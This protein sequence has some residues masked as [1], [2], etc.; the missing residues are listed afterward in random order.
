[1]TRK[2]TPLK[3]GDVNRDVLKP[4]CKQVGFPVGMMHAFR[5][6]RVS[7]MDSGGTSRKLIKLEIEHSSLRLTD[8]YTHFTGQQRKVRLKNWLFDYPKIV[9]NVVD[10]TILAG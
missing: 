5:H 6:G 3:S 8:G 9:P 10:A 2:G 7:A 1:M 4:I